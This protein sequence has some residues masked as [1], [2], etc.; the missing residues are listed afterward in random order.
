MS[1]DEIIALAQSSMS[2]NHKKAM[3]MSAS[4]I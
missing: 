4:K 3:S 2:N 1:V